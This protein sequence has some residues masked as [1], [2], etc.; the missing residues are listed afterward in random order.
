MSI[1]RR[2]APGAEDPVNPYLLVPVTAATALVTLSCIVMLMGGDQRPNRR[3]ATFGFTSAWWALCEIFWNSATTADTALLLHKIAAPG[4]VYIGPLTVHLLVTVTDAEDTPFA[5]SVPW[6]YAASTVFLVLA[7]TTD[8]MLAGMVRTPWGWGLVPGPLFAV[9]A[10]YTA[11]TQGISI[12]VWRT[13]T[14]D[15]RNYVERRVS[16]VVTTGVF[17]ATTVG[18]LTDGLLPVLGVQAPRLATA[19]VALVG[20]LALWGLNRYGFARLTPRA[21]SNRILRTLPDGVAL[22]SLNGRV[23]QANQKLVE[24]IGIAQD[25]LVGESIAPYVDYPLLDPPREL[26]EVEHELVPYEGPPIPVSISAAPLAE[27]GGMQGLVLI[28]RDLREVVALRKR[29]MTSGRLASVGQLAAGIAHEINNPLAFVRSNLN[30]LRGDWEQL[31][32]ALLKENVVMPEG[33]DD[34]EDLL[35]EAIDGV[36]RAVTIVR[37][38][39]DF[40]HVGGGARELVDVRSLLDHAVRVARPQLGPD[41]RVETDYQDVEPVPCDPQRL[42]QLFLNLV[43]N[44]GQAIEGAGTIRIGLRR[45]QGY[46]RVTV[47]DDG[48]G[49]PPDV[50]DRIFDPFFTTKSVGTGTGLGLSISHEIVRSHNGHIWV[51]SR[52]GEGSAFHVRIPVEPGDR[53]DEVANAPERR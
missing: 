19:C 16:P 21:F 17:V 42:R 36:D 23:L 47:Q 1:L 26:H 13:V 9:F 30:L 49:I 37:D 11:V 22:L 53:A 12:V 44:A 4:F 15:S 38:V 45:D 29:L 39:R 5:R 3:V 8:W 43:I 32:S 40:S 35:D 48:C 28:V 7:V 2:C 52:P 6:L 51:D 50:A 34:W 27:K 18:V 20:S 46:V 31:K 33:G 24:L 14:H 41:V 10:L 25:D